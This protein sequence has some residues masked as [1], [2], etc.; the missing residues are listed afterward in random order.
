MATPPINITPPEK[1]RVPRDSERALTEELRANL[2]DPKR[3][4]AIVGRLYREIVTS[5]EG[6]ER[7]VN[8]VLY[9]DGWQDALDRGFGRAP[10]TVEVEGSGVLAL[11]LPVDASPELVLA[12]AGLATLAALA[13][14]AS[15]AKVDTE[16]EPPPITRTVQALPETSGKVSYVNSDTPKA[17]DRRRIF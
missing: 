4:K 12:L 10:Q 11:A 13:D 6:L 3:A 17:P 8:E 16:D 2:D 5:E 14:R 7:M 15:E 1:L 9:G